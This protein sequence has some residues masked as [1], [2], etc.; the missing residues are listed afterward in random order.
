MI[1]PL[2]YVPTYSLFGSPICFNQKAGAMHI[3]IN[4]ENPDSW[5]KIS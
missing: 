4:S 5:P 2:I 3:D 1:V